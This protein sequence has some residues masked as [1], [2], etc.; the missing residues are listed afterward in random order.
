MHY[1]LV[2]RCVRR[3]WLCGVDRQ[4][5]K[6]YEHRKGWLE[7]RIHHLAQYFAVAVDAYAIMS[8]HFHLVVYFDPQEC[9]RWSDEQVAKRWLA[10]FPPRM[11]A[12]TADKQDIA[13]LHREI[14]LRMP[15]KLLH[16]RQT[17]GSLSMFMKHLK[18]PV[19]YQANKEDGCSG[20]FF[21]GRFYSGA[22]L[23]E[24][25]VVA[26]MA[27]VDLNPIRARIVKHIDEY[28]AASGYKRAQVAI[29]T[30][31]RLEAAIE[32]LVS[33]LTD[34]RPPLATTLAAYLNILERVARDYQA[35][36]SVDK[37][38]RWFDRI[39]SL[40]KRQR[41]FGSM[42]ALS[43]WRTD[44]GWSVTGSPLPVA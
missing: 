39:A 10:V 15:E 40:R 9:N 42:A 18:Q 25:A 22:L 21:E 44:R 7:A 33:G 6:D 41:A 24:N 27:Y 43:N 1:H 35:P 32:P 31:D 20:H 28:K 12:S 3:S 38:S 4:A 19:A 37:T 11:S 5:R 2:S 30:L 8:N 13:N 23:D 36:R 29:N 17:L 16:A 14:L 26:A 34:P